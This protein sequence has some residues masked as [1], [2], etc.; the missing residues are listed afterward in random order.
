MDYEN[1]TT[2]RVDVAAGIARVTFD[3][4][5]INLMDLPMIMDLDR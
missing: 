4:G 3:N 1:F 2:L 5:P